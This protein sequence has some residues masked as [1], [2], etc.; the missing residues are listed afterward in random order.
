VTTPNL[1]VATQFNARN[2]N[3]TLGNVDLMRVAT[4]A[5]GVLQSTTYDGTHTLA[6]VLPNLSYSYSVATQGGASFDANG[7]P[8]QG[9]WTVALPR[10]T[11]T[12]SVAGGSASISID[13]GADG[14]IDRSFSVPVARL[15]SD[16]G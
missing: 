3:F 8:T 2:A 12:I 11:L 15:G 9:G 5:S 13:D 4:F 6:A 14:S 16:A 10:R 7:V 1:A